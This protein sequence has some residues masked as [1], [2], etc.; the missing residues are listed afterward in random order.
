[1]HLTGRFNQVTGRKFPISTARAT[2]VPN[3]HLTL[4]RPSASAL[5]RARD[6]LGAMIALAAPRP[7][8]PSGFAAA[9]AATLLCL[10]M[11]AAPALG[12]VAPAVGRSG[13]CLG[14]DGSRRLKI[15]F[16]Y[17]DGF[18]VVS[19]R[20]DGLLPVKF[21]F[22]TGSDHT[23]LTDESLLALIGRVP[24][25]PIRIVG[26]DLSEPL[27][28]ALMRRTTIEVGDVVIRSQPLVILDDPRL[29]L[30]AITGQPVYGILGTR[31]FAAYAVT[32]DYAAEELVLDPHPPRRLGRGTRTLP[33]EVVG[34]KAYVTAS[35]RIHPAYA[36]S[37]RLLLDT[38]AS[39]AMLMH[40]ERG[41]TLLYPPELVAGQIGYGLGGS[42]YGYVGRSDT[43]G[44]GPFALPD[45]VTHF[46]TLDEPAYRD[47]VAPRRGVIGNRLLDRFLVTIDYPRARLHLRPTRRYSRRR[48]YDRSGLRL[49]SDGADLT[50][51]RVQLVVDGSPSHRA[52]VRVGDRITHINGVPVRLTGLGGA[53]RRLRRRPGRKIRLRLLRPGGETF[54]TFRLREMI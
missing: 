42:L 23:I 5:R 54:A 51:L 52:G 8:P 50:H 22:D 43:L 45:V 10:L 1:M 40:A 30:A 32:I 33:L 24:D 19:L 41:D 35:A 37:L 49:V 26:S 44:L 34:G 12:A 13:G 47:A 21:I 25:E 16:D 29:D 15:P 11:G 2:E 48:P 6:T 53:K 14:V 27:D 3:P 20:L 18:I 7:T 46:Q 31:A 17:V 4:T 28:G 39:L 38:G 36:D 9:A